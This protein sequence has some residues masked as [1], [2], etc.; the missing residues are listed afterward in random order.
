[1]AP[2]SVHHAVVA[3]W[4][5]RRNQVLQESRSEQLFRLLGSTGNLV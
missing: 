3:T 4:V 1:M 2:Q 5:S